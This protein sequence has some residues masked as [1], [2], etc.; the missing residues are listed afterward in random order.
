[1]HRGWQTARIRKGRDE[2][3]RYEYRIARRAMQTSSAAGKMSCDCG[4]EAC[5]NPFGYADAGGQSWR[6]PG[7]WDR[8]A[9]L[10]CVL[11]RHILLKVVRRIVA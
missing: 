1:M 4:A 9:Q 3:G 6:L 5:L 8:E 10:A 7:I 2:K 11:G